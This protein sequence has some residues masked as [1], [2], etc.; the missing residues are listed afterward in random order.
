MKGKR[1]GNREESGK[2]GE[3]E[4]YGREGGSGGKRERIMEEERKD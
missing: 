4:E 2:E 3:R 1:K